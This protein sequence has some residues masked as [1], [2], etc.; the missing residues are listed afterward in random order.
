[1]EIRNA[2][3]AERE[4]LAATL[5]GLSERDWDRETLC[6][7]WRVREVVAHMTMAYRYSLPRF[8]LGMVKARGNFDAMAD[9]AARHDAAVMTADALA[10]SMANNARHP[11][12]P[13]GGGYEG[14]LTHDVI[15]GLDITLPLGLGRK[16]PQD[17]LRIVLE[18]LQ[19]DKARKYFGVDLSGIE[20]RAVDMDWSFGSGATLRGS[21]QDL[22]LVVCGRKLPKGSLEGEASERFTAA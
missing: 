2:I 14:A 18:G 16:V 4:E 3:A 5:R 22:A 7:G 8:L 9:R 1:M 12:K 6:E 10:A 13:P 15:H 20:L 11:W 19:A 17:R 21:A